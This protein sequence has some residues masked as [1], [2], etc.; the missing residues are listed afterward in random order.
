[1]F[2]QELNTADRWGE[3]AASK[4]GDEL[5]QPRFVFERCLLACSF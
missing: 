4:R 1:M 2:N 3:N 5:F